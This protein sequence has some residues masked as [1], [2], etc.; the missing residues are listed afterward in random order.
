MYA[1]VVALQCQASAFGGFRL[2]IRFKIPDNSELLFDSPAA[3]RAAGVENE[4]L[5]SRVARLRADALPAS[6]PHEQ[7]R[8]SQQDACDSG[9]HG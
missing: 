2:P 6:I 4:R 9:H 7:G 8:R 1:T 5:F 3:R